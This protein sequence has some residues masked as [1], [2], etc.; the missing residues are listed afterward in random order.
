MGDK[1]C[2][3]E[4]AVTGVLSRGCLK[5][6][7]ATF[8]LVED[9]LGGRETSLGACCMLC[10]GRD[11]IVKETCQLKKEENMLCSDGSEVDNTFCSSLKVGR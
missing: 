8:C 3:L 9:T 5:S 6:N 11:R 10:W 1:T 4:A 2:D 7:W